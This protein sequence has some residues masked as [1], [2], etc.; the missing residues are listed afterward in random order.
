MAAGRVANRRPCYLAHPDDVLADIALYEGDALTASAHYEAEL[1]GA[2]SAADPIRLVMIVD[3]I[4]MCQQAFGTPEAGVPYAEEAILVADAAGNPTARS[5][6]RCTLGRALAGADPDRALALLDD[7][8]EI[9]AS[10]DNNWCTGMAGMEAA[11]IRAEHGDPI[12]AAPTLIPVLDHWEHGGPGLIAQQW[13]TLRH[14]TRLL[15]RLGAQTDA[16]RLQR[17][18]VDAGREPPL[19]DG[20][21][22]RLGGVGGGV[23]AEADVVEFARAALRR[24][25]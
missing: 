7:A 4:T 20:E 25:C 18:F 2:R 22:A 11:A 8:Y 17:F 15:V 3:R 12:A 10:V 6:A 14:V 24:Y 1:P 5:L 9:G 21:A 19:S 13:D 16:A 23:P